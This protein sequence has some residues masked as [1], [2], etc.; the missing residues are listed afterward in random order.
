MSVTLLRF[1]FF[2]F[3]MGPAMLGRSISRIVPFKSAMAAI[4]FA[5]IALLFFS[6]VSNAAPNAPSNLT[7]CSSTGLSLSSFTWTNSTLITSSFTL[8]TASVHYRIQVS[9]VT[10][11]NGAAVWNKGLFVDAT[12]AALLP[13]GTTWYAWTPAIPAFYWWRVS[14]FD[15]SNVYSST[16]SVLQSGGPA[17]VAW[18]TPFDPKYREP[19]PGDG[20]GGG[21]SSLA[22][23]D[24]DGDGYQDLAILGNSNSSGDITKVFPG[25]SDGTF[26]AAV[27]L[28]SGQTFSSGGVAWGDFNNDGLLDLAIAG[29]NSTTGNGSVRVYRNTGGAFSAT[30]VSPETVGY[31]FSNLAWGDY[32]N[33][34]CLNLVVAGWTDSY[35]IV[36][37]VYHNNGNA[38]FTV[39]YNNNF[40]V[41][42][43]DVGSCAPSLQWLD[44][45]NDGDLDLA[46]AGNAGGTYSM[47]IYRNQN[48]TFAFGSAPVFEY[49]PVS[50]AAW[51]DFNNDG[52]MDF[53]GVDS[54][55]RVAVFLNTG[56]FTFNTVS[57]IVLTS[58][59]NNFTNVAAGDVDND[60]LSDVFVAGSTG[61]ALYYNRNGSFV[62]QP[63]FPF[64][65]LYGDESIA[66]ADYN[67][68]GALDAAFAGGDLFS[69]DYLRVFNGKQAN[70]APVP[71]TISTVTFSY[72]AT[73]STFTV[74]WAPGYYDVGHSSNS[75]YYN[76]EVATY[77]TTLQSD[78]K[79]VVNSNKFVES[80][81]FG[82]PNLGSYIRPAVSTNWAGVKGTQ[83]VGY[84]I[85]PSTSNYLL[86]ATTFYFRV[87][88]IDSG[89][90]RSVWSSE[91]ACIASSYVVF[92]NHAPD[93]PANL[94][95]L[96]G[97]FVSLSSFSW[98]NSGTII[99]SFTL[100]D[101]DAGT[102]VKYHLQITT[103]SDSGL[104]TWTSGYFL[105]YT[106]PLLNQGTTTYTWPA[107][108]AN[109][110]YWWQVWT[111]DAGGL[112]STSTSTSLL[113]GG[114]AALAYKTVYDPNAMDVLPGWGVG[115]TKTE[116]AW[117]DMDN[118]G[119]ADLAIAGDGE[120]RVFKNNKDGTMDPNSIAVDPA[121]GGLNTVSVKWGDFNNDGKLDLV[122]MGGWWYGTG[123]NLRVYYNNGAGGF[124]PNYEEPVPDWGLEGGC[125]APGDY[126]NDGNLDIAVMGYDGS[127]A[128]FQVYRN[129][130]DGTFDPDYI[131]PQ[132][133][134]GTYAG[135]LAWGD[136]NNDGDLD[137]A[138]HG[139]DSYLRIFK[140]NGNG[141]F[142][143]HPI[144]LGTSGDWEALAWGD[145]NNDGNLDISGLDSSDW[146]YLYTN[147][148][149]GSF[150]DTR[151]TIDGV[152]GS[153]NNTLCVGDFDNDGYTDIAGSY[154]VG[155]Y[156]YVDNRAYI[157]HNNS[158]A[159][160]FAKSE[161]L[162]GWG[163]SFGSLAFADFDND[164]DLDLAVSGRENNC[165]DYATGGY[166]TCIYK[167][168]EAQLGNPNTPPTAPTGLTALYAYDVN[169]S[170]LTLCWTPAASYYNIELS[171]FPTTLSGGNLQ[172]ATTGHYE[173]PWNFGSP[174]TGNYTRPPSKTWPGLSGTKAGQLY[175]VPDYDIEPGATYYF[176]AQAINAS[177]I[178]G[179]WSSEFS[180]CPQGAFSPN[181]PTGISQYKENGGAVYLS[182]YSWVQGS[183]IVVS[184]FTLTS[185]NAGMQVR[186]RIQ[187]T[188]VT[189]PNTA[190]A[191]WG[192][193]ILVDY[194]S[195][196]LT[197][198]ATNYH[199]QLPGS[200]SSLCWWRI[201]CIDQNG[202]SSE[203]VPVLN[204]GGA[205]MVAYK[206]I[207]A[208]KA[209]DVMPGWGVV[210]YKTGLAWGDMNNDGWQ[211]LAAIGNNNF[212][213]F[214]NKK[215]GTFDP[216]TVDP[217]WSGA[218]TS[219][220]LKWGDFNNDGNLDLVALGYTGAGNLRV[221]Y[222][223]GSG[224]FRSSYQE[225]IPGWGLYN[226]DIAPGDYN[227]D[228]NL[229]IAV[230]GTDGSNNYFRI[231]RNKGDGTFDPNPIEP[232]P[233][234]GTYAGALAWA[235][236]NND[237]DLDIA[238]KGIDSALRIYK[239]NGDGSFYSPMD[240]SSVAY[241]DWNAMAWDD[242][243]NDGYLDLFCQDYNG[244]DLYQNKGDGT[245]NTS[246]VSV[247]NGA[248]ANTFA[249]CIGDFDNDGY[250]DI[251]DLGSINA[252]L[253]H[254]NGGSGSFTTSP[255]RP[256]WGVPNNVSIA[257]ADFD[258]D[259]DLDLAVSGQDST[260][261]NL[262]CIFS[263]EEAQMGNANTAPVPPSGIQSQTAYNITKSTMIITWPPAQY[264]IGKSS[265]T[266]S[267]QVVIA[268]CS[269][270]LAAD[271]KLIA[272]PGSFITTWAAEGDS[273]GNYNR[274]PVK[275]W[276]TDSTPRQGFGL[277]LSTASIKADTTYYYRVQT[278]DSCLARSTWSVEGM[279][280]MGV[281]A[282]PAAITNLTAL[283]GSSGGEIKLSWS[284][285][286]ADGTANNIINGAFKIRY[287]TYTT[288]SAN[289]WTDAA[290]NWVDQTN[291]YQITIP[292]NSIPGV[293]QS[294][295]L[296]G[297]TPGGTYYVRAW[298]RD[299]VGVDSTS[300]NGNW[301]ALSNAAT[302]YSMSATTPQVISDLVA[303]NNSALS[304]ITLTWTAP[305][306]NGQTGDLNAG[307]A[308]KIEY[309]TVNVINTNNFAVMQATMA[310]Q[311]VTISTVTTAMSRQTYNIGGLTNN[312]KYW[313]AIETENSGGVWSAW[314]SSAPEDGHTTYNV[315]AS[316]VCSFTNTP[317]TISA[318]EQ[319]DGSLVSMTSF[320]WT[321]SGTIISSFTISDA[322]YGQLVHYN[323]QITSVVTNNGVDWTNIFASSRSALISQGTVSYTWPALTPNAFYAW[324]AGRRIASA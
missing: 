179:Q 102:Q 319:L 161:I 296:V 139:T 100:T 305:G 148:G 1:T 84:T 121:L 187:I 254:N 180:I 266:L 316:T 228:G 111:E 117:G 175:T 59:I 243:N 176:R 265:C 120:F 137:I 5:V 285:P 105:N 267:Y 2:L 4:I 94:V 154:G 24:F 256:A 122:E 7:Q 242:Y 41:A 13:A 86:N 65:P 61:T 280:Y 40:G 277:C 238:V 274:P 17:V 240:L 290:S 313:F 292:T 74:A 32:D 248:S 192:H 183:D 289:F 96:D 48:S 77:P 39:A 216:I 115:Y 217:A 145:F 97:S 230:I 28:P 46:M 129:N 312:K 308:F 268:T 318:L 307:S 303:T 199:W 21:G 110:F 151:V 306:S 155:N 166:R 160:T 298:A 15:G 10:D 244:L 222:N 208:P 259:N 234:W 282:P 275:I 232:Q 278:I 53:A 57:P 224:G 20:I 101:Q 91:Y 150:D 19:M 140:N 169:T 112:A 320:T 294:A 310:I 271:Q 18:N 142:D 50:A 72:S 35:A 167:N 89:L 174:N 144:E 81:D 123:Y 26:N 34:G 79:R 287:S 288:G 261:Q 162:P 286:G 223:N 45:E 184:S 301:S 252:H 170:T 133:G 14:C 30:F 76:V 62:N 204:D 37:R 229:D 132:P 264:D 141:S 195:G 189:L 131:E 212:L 273:F 241:G 22:W 321:N 272:A 178:K 225:P 165:I 51:G 95:Q 236:Y 43:T 239:N 193:G 158:G 69:A 75:V 16:T 157:Y 324:R 304:A 12:S 270:T 194:T 201:S 191:D 73:R 309:S 149:D 130:G 219:A 147:N 291:K 177:L 302:A 299:E 55:S 108:A 197:Q 215:D 262:F 269:M 188:T 203:P 136:Y 152:A 109:K 186:Y 182:S 260:S 246:G 64:W 138:V 297:L 104:A 107:L 293:T 27:T 190:A 251:A 284:S 255:L 163:V 276:G 114:P 257:F 198:G 311:G 283:K 209:L 9:T 78:N 300:W 70:A 113:S 90:M 54:N 126:D 171:T 56:N 6:I 258:N 128:Y 60:G 221:Y 164:N 295:T 226:G 42:S 71:P 322:N 281:G 92:T 63:T 134:W 58:T 218:A 206:T 213:L 323:I 172:L 317:P 38:G 159:G 279:V 31:S 106:S 119:Y 207:F 173:M 52:F 85:A 23:G 153:N 196:L 83:M 125:V 214:K 47:S 245:F 233:G 49:D 88:T 127:N 135:T 118:D 98:T 103:V 80:W 68:D 200:V 87:Q 220:A 247:Y 314:Y 146:L 66:L 181:P 25:K 33:D 227:N 116:L 82:S 235:D 124:D 202:Y 185:P 210:Y 250:A 11:A 143:P 93:A 156:P 249:M 99:S 168:K 29:K 205:A 237:G 8:T 3:C 263:N 315:L 231:F 36:S 211:D 67:A 253:Y 44:V